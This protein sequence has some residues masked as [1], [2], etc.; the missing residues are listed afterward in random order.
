MH[1][2]VLLIRSLPREA[3]DLAK[4]P[5]MTEELDLFLVARAPFLFLPPPPPCSKMLKMRGLLPLPI[6][7]SCGWQFLDLLCGHP[8]LM[9]VSNLLP[10]SFPYSS[11]I[12]S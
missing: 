1:P 11:I 10:F 3:K 7:T 9:V 8:Q 6:P 5:K 2:M 12:L 4:L